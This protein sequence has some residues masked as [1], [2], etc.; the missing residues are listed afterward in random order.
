MVSL[1]SCSCLKTEELGCYV[2]RISLFYLK[3]VN[4]GVHVD[5]TGLVLELLFRSEKEECTYD[6]TKDSERSDDRYYHSVYPYAIP[7][8][9]SHLHYSIPQRNTFYRYIKVKAYEC[10]PPPA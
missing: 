1:L 10:P 9:F 8:D 6:K 7:C 4:L 3:P 5:R 2:G